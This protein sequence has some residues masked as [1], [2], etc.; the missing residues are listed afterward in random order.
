M[1]QKEREWEPVKRQKSGLPTP[2]HGLNRCKN[3]IGIGGVRVEDMM[4]VA[5]IDEVNE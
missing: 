5:S 1:L 4:K 3:Q 2:N